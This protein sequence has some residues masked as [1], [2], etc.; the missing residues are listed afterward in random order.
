VIYCKVKGVC[1]KCNTT[2]IENERISEEDEEDGNDSIDN[3]S[4][5]W[6]H[7]CRAKD[8]P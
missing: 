8:D 3:G 7:D 1:G 6:L 2:G 4:L 5:G